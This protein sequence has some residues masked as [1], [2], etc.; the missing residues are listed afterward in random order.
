MVVQGN[1]MHVVKLN[2]DFQRTIG[3]H[4]FLN[5]IVVLLLVPIF[6]L[7]VYPALAKCDVH[8]TK[9]QRIGVG[10]V[11]ATVSMVCAGGIELYRKEQCCKQLHAGGDVN[12]TVEIS[13]ATIFYQLP[14]YTLLGLSQ[15]FTVVTGKYKY[16]RN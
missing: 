3:L 4:P 15:V 10:M 7:M 14:Q 11:V 5:M 2:S 8:L 13:N 12:K 1:H 9:L 16:L 6:D